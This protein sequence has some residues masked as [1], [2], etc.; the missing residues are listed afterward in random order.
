MVE[1]YESLYGRLDA[2]HGLWEIALGG[3]KLI[4]GII[5]D[6]ASTLVLL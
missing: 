2:S 3:E 1:E 4:L 5:E 6:R